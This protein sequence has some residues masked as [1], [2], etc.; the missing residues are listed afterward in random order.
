M[1]YHGPIESIEV[2][3]EDYVRIRLKWVA[4]MKA[5]LSPGFDGTWRK[6]SDDAKEI[7]FPNLVVPFRFERTEE[8]GPRVRFGYNLLYLNAVPGV[9]SARVEGLSV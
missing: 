4:E 7:V 3:A 6:A 9:D 5:P 8:K 1:V 2:D